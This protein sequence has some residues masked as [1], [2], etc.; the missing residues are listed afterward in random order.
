[1]R[2]PIACKSGFARSALIAILSFPLMVSAHADTPVSGSFW[3]GTPASFIK[4]KYARAIKGEPAN[5][6][7]TTILV[8]TE[9]D[10][11]KSVFDP[12]RGELVGEDVGDG[13]IL[14]ITSDGKLVWIKVAHDIEIYS[15]KLS[16][17][18]LYDFNS[19]D[20]QVKGKISTFGSKTLVNDKSGAPCLGGCPQWNVDLSFSVA[21]P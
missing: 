16:Q 8:L 1:M 20:G 5:T 18:E 11:S 17:V 19:D 14:S 9:R 13:L 4:L 3:I 12:V 15:P 7:E 6:K 21:A 10:S 2:S